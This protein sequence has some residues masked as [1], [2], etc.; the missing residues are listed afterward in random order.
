[1]GRHP[2]VGGPTHVV[3]Q[4]GLLELHQHAK[5]ACASCRLQRSRLISFAGTVYRDGMHCADVET[6]LGLEMLSL[7]SL[8]HAFLEW[9][10]GLW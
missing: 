6:A 5:G 10:V 2:D 4:A 3:I 1:V 9:R 8:Q 7:D